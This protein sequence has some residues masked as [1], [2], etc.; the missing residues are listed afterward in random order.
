MSFD[1][2]KLKAACVALDG[3]ELLV[4]SQLPDSIWPPSNESPTL[5][6]QLRGKA[7]ACIN[8]H[9]QQPGD[10]GGNIIEGV[11]LPALSYYEEESR[12]F[13]PL[14]SPTSAKPV[15]IK[16]KVKD[17]LT[18]ALNSKN[19]ALF[20]DVFQKLYTTYQDK[21]LNF[22]D[23]SDL[24]LQVM[25]RLFSG[26]HVE[27]AMKFLRS[28]TSS[29]RSQTL[30]QQLSYAANIKNKNMMDCVIDELAE[31]EDWD[32]RSINEDTVRSILAAFLSGKLNGTD[33]CTAFD[34]LQKLMEFFPEQWKSQLESQED[35]SHFEFLDYF[36]GDQ[37]KWLES[38]QLKPQV[39]QSLI[40]SMSPG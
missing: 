32:I 15:S 2:V 34:V 38:F 1:M 4:L 40:D 20:F 18:S 39:K 22:V 7:I 24:Q 37:S 25:D 5:Q 28:E 14:P 8:Q 6:E 35:I 21:L 16:D 12:H 13:V 26:G 19:E 11:Y 23:D 30:L 31:L 10:D 36:H 29:T 27:I 33:S 3:A 9:R 17:A